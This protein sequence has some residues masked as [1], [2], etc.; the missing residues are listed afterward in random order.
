MSNPNHAELMASLPAEAR[1]LVEA[2]FAENAELRQSKAR[3]PAKITAKVSTKGAVS[4]YGLQRFPVTLYA[5]QWQRLLGEEG[6]AAVN[7]CIAENTDKLT[8]K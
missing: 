8:T 1:A 7:T 3:K 4:V 2:T 5:Q 6:V